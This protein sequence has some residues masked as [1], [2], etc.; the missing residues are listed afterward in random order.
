MGEGQEGGDRATDTGGQRRSRGDHH[1]R[2]PRLLG[3]AN[4][5]A[6]H[7]LARN[8]A[9]VE[10]G[11][12]AHH[13]K[14]RRRRREDRHAATVLG[15]GRAM[16]RGH[17]FGSGVR[18]LLCPGDRERVLLSVHH[19]RRGVG[20]GLGRRQAPLRRVPT[21][22]AVVRHRR[23][24]ERRGRVCNARERR[25]LDWGGLDHRLNNAGGHAALDT[26]TDKGHCASVDADVQ[27]R[28]A[29]RRDWCRSRGCRDCGSHRDSRSAAPLGGN[30]TCGKRSHRS[31][32]HCCHP[33]LWRGGSKGDRAGHAGGG[34]RA[35][36]DGVRSKR[37]AVCRQVEPGLQ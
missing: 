14:A 27:E 33:R 30:G 18:R 11:V 34:E 24:H 3:S 22:H 20:E 37:H 17:R 25:R 4:D 26:G 29:H 36:G 9:A 5:H 2:L 32:R 13:G 16:V 21:R 35:H 6:Q 15:G 31:W 23:G 10:G 7:Q 12:A 8:R 1:R 28:S 19:R